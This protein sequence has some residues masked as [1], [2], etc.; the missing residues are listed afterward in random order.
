MDLSPFKQDIDELIDE[1]SQVE[2]TS[3]SDMKRLWASKKFTFIYE[4]APSPNSYSAS[5]AA[6]FMQSLFAHCLGHVASFSSLSHRLGGLYCLYCLYE[7]QPFKPPF[8]IYLCLR[9]L[10][11]I[12]ELVSAAKERGV[13]VVLTLIKR[14]LE[15]NM[16][17]FGAVDVNETSFTERVNHLTELQDAR[18]KLAYKKLFAST[19]I[20][21]FLHM[22]LVSEV[23][24]DI[25]KRMSSEYAE[26]KKLAIKE[27][28][29]MVDVQD[30]EHI[31]EEKEQI[32]NVLEKIANEWSVERNH[33]YQQTGFSLHSD[34]EQPLL[35]SAQEDDM[36]FEHKLELILY[37][38]GEE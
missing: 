36:D 7:T 12:K 6:F 3:F 31:A 19:Q 20:E 22:D 25:V 33:F 1:F 35:P 9:D 28:R 2:S 8:R 38:E 32:G 27:A 11:N 15:R 21:H 30:I 5:N 24:T 4:A 10:R 18:V 14:M 13:A 37:G 29:H 23:D 34:G 17:L 16:F 26:A